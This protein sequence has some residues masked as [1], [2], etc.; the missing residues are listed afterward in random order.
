MA[1][2]VPV[3]TCEW[4]G[5]DLMRVLPKREQRERGLKSPDRLE[6]I[7]L[8]VAPLERWRKQQGNVRV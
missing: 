6:S 8:S 1:A 3:A 2:T 7:C 5:E 4:T